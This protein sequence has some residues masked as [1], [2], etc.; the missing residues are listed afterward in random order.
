MTREYKVLYVTKSTSSFPPF[1]I[2]RNERIYDGGKP[3]VHATNK[4]IR[5]AEQ[6]RDSTT[7]DRRQDG[8]DGTEVTLA[9]SGFICRAVTELLPFAEMRA[10]GELST[11]SHRGWKYTRATFMPPPTRGVPSNV[12][13]RSEHSKIDSRLRSARG[14]LSRAEEASCFIADRFPEKR[15]APDN[16]RIACPRCS[17]RSLHRRITR[18]SIRGNV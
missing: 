17:R 9:S 15:I 6:T 3:R 13:A 5:T 14:L 12:L 8:E 4:T 16:E 1:C 18:V 2:P 10:G 7:R 11:S